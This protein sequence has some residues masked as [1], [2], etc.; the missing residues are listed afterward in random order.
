MKFRGDHGNWK[1]GA[2]NLTVLFPGGA[3]EMAMDWGYLKYIGPWGPYFWF[4]DRWISGRTAARL[5]IFSASLIAAWTVTYFVAG[6]YSLWANP[7]SSGLQA[8]WTVLDVAQVPAGLFLWYGML[9]F[10]VRLDDSRAWIK[11]L[12]LVAMIVGFWWGAS[13]YC[14]VVYV[15]RASKTPLLAAA[16][17]Q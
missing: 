11:R 3:S 16:E 13:V 8:V 6:R 1:L 5:F 9:R 7:R 2:A 15:R 14:L 17:P 4:S 12:S 10:W